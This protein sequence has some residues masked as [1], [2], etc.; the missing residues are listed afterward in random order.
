M[1][2]KV[3]LAAGIYAT[4]A[5][6]LIA[7]CSTS[8]APAGV[9]TS[10]G[11]SAPAGVATS[12]GTSAPAGGATSSGRSATSG[13]KTCNPGAAS[14]S[15]PGV[16]AAQQAITKAASATAWGGP[17][18]GPKGQ[19]S[20]ATVVFIPSN[21]TNVGDTGVLAGFQ[22][23]AKVLGWNVKVIDG[24]GTVSSNVAAFDQALALKPAGIM[25]SSFDPVSSKAEF[26][27]AKAA[28]VPVVGNH[29]GGTAGP[30][31][32]DPDLFTNITSDPA[33][34]AKIAADC[35]IVTSG[36]TAGVT[37]YGCGSEFSICN[38]KEDAM[39]AEI[40]KCSRCTML[41]RTDYPFE[42]LTQRQ[43][44]IS[45]AAVQKYGSKLTYMLSI[46]DGYW[47]ASI[48]A[49]KALGVGPS[50]PPLMI[51]AG[52]GSPAA[53]QR[54]RTGQYQ[55]A[56]VAEPL[57]EHGWQGADELN[58]AIAGAKDS[59][60]VTYPHIVTSSNIDAEGGKNNAYDPTND[61]KAHYEQIWG[62]SG[63]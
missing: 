39:E 59:G 45:A 49:L 35:A 12:S 43:G 10:S 30:Q 54:I 46:N 24:R 29:T 57:N 17:T 1:K 14:S 20:G 44:G 36:G 42:D 22:E 9:A 40:K 8:S 21:S 13:L 62:V 55:I 11:T 51:A 6:A 58:R 5:F 63:N 60:Y 16:Q 37:I 53:F 25:V 56:T 34:I 23:A 31:S 7:G 18:T 41:N 15:D 28:G 61:Y 19:K 26:A 4:A 3:I 52:D 38:T 48:P 33:T 2:T 47:D 32:D 50:G 27:K